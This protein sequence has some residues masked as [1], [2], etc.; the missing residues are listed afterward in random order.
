MPA[1]KSEED[2]L[3][4]GMERL[5]ASA[6]RIEAALNRDIETV[7]ARALFLGCPLRSVLD[8]RRSMKQHDPTGRSD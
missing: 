8:Q 5:G 6:A 2:E 3:L 7:R 1:W 4:R